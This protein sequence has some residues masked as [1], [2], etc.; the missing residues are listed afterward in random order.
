MSYLSPRRFFII[1]K[2][3]SE[4]LST[5]EALY[6]AQFPKIKMPAS[7][8]F[9]QPEGFSVLKKQSSLHGK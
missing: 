8:E 9:S 1:G 3:G 2:F 6:N 7:W 5:F 4:L